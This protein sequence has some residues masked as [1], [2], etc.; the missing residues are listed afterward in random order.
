MK[1]L[2]ELRLGV[3]VAGQALP[4]VTPGGAFGRCELKRNVDARGGCVRRDCV[5]LSLPESV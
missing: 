3:D 1:R 2:G 4:P 5:A